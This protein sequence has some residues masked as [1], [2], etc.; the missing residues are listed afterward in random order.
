M[1]AKKGKDNG[2]GWLFGSALAA[3]AA[4]F[5]TVKIAEYLLSGAVGTVANAAKAGVFTAAGAAA[6]AGSGMRAFSAWVRSL[7]Q[8]VGKQK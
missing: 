6:F 5:V 2:M 4:G 7:R 8:L 3:L 1:G